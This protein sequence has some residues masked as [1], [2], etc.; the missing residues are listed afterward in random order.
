MELL[1]NLELVKRHNLSP[2][3][4]FFLVSL[5]T[6]RQ[7]LWDIPHT[8]LLVLERDGWI[9]IGPEGPV[10]RSKFKTS[11]S[12]YL[13]SQGVEEWIN[14][15]RHIW[16]AGVKTGNRLV[17]G[18]KQGCVKKMKKFLKENPEYSKQDVFDAARVYIFEALRQRSDKIICAD[19]FIE[20]NGSSQLSAYLEDTE[21]RAAILE[22]IQGGGNIFHQEV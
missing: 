10:I 11:F 4:Y 21:N 13:T 2:T 16:P 14:D 22:Q 8:N 5:Y 3:L 20:K 19:Y 18:D 17:R 9:K 7:Y 6:G 12:K 1:C 15:W